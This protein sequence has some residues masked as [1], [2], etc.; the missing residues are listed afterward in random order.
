MPI[1]R[2]PV[3]ITW[4]GSGSPGVNVWHLRVSDVTVLVDTTNWSAGSALLALSQFYTDISGVIPSDTKFVIGDRMVNVETNEELQNTD[5]RDQLGTGG[6]M[7]LPPSNQIVVGWR[8]VLAAR[9]GRGRTFIGP[10]VKG[11]ASDDGTP[12]PA[13][14]TT[15]TDAANALID[16]SDNVN[17]WAFGVY[18][19][20]N[21]HAPAT[22]VLRDFT[23][24]NVRDTFA[25]LRSRRD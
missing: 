19:Q 4:P 14:L 16:A 9:R 6:T 15:I 2:V 1:V 3:E 17:G 23:R 5:I 24:C 18:G 22:K 13:A 7:K 21:I 12:T 11:A 25:V 8:S 10:L 20:E